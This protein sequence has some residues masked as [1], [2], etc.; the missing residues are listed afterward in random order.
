MAKKSANIVEKL[1]R[2]YAFA[3][4]VLSKIWARTP[5]EALPL[6]QQSKELYEPLILDSVLTAAVQ[7][8]YDNIANKLTEFGADPKR[9]ELGKKLL[10]A[11]RHRRTLEALELME[12]GANVN[13]CDPLFWETPLFQAIQTGNKQLI[14]ALTEHGAN[15]N[16]HIYW[17]RRPP[18]GHISGN[19]KHKCPL[20]CAYD[21]E[22]E[23]DLTEEIAFLKEHGAKEWESLEGVVAIVP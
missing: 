18:C 6:F 3:N 22:E 8:G 11:V 7:R 5:E 10:S 15:V 4:E 20:S 9:A 2:S 13:F 1:N 23:H 17:E 16:H 21:Y 14:R 19:P 12:K